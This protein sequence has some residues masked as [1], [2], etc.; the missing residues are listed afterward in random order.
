MS[1]LI[2]V[3]G[4]SAIPD[5]GTST[6][7]TVPSGKAAKVKL[8]YRGVAGANSVLT[9][10][11]NGIVIFTTAA[12]AAG[13]VSHSTT[14]LEHNT[15]AASAVDGSSDAKT[16]APGPKEYYLSAGDTVSYTI[17]TLAFSAMNFQ[18]VGV[19]IDVA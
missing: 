8:M 19:E 13:N 6:A 12:L 18:V 14:L 5:L 2:G 3:L 17:A 1:D 15:Q 7:Y 4:Q 10:T 16:V 11:V 9:V